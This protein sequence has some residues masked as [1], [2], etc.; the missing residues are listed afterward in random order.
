MQRFEPPP[1]QAP[2]VPATPPGPPVPRTS[3]SIGEST[4]PPWLAAAA[5]DVFA[6]CDAFA[7]PDDEGEYDVQIA[8]ASGGSP[9]RSHSKRDASTSPLARCLLER[10]CRLHGTSDAPAV[11]TTVPVSVKW[12]F[13]KP[14]KRTAR[15]AGNP[16][17]VVFEDVDAEKS[18]AFPYPQLRAVVRQVARGCSAGMVLGSTEA[19]VVVRYDDAGRLGEV[20]SEALLPLD[21]GVV[22]CLA[23]ETKAN[24]VP[25]I[26]RGPL[27]VRLVVDFE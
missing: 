18:G 26:P 15:A 11:D 13:P 20:R 2:L 4:S 10:A 3:I 23:G 5:K 9:L 8:F 14:G 21:E 1:Q 16:P 25:K 6:D 7:T 19:R 27:E 22:H 12:K 24:A 17:F